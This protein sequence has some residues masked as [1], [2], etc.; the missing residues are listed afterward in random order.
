MSHARAFIESGNIEVATANSDGTLNLI[1]RGEAP[2]LVRYE[3]AY[4]ATTLTVMG[5]RSGFAWNNPPE[6]NYVDTLVYDKLERI[7]VV[8]SDLCSDDEFLRRVYID[9]T[10][11]PPSRDTVIAF[12]KDERDSKVKRDELVDKL[13][14]SPEFVEYWTNKWADL[15]QV[16]RKFLGEQAAVALRDWIKNAVATNQPYDDFARDILTA[17]GSNLQNPPASYYKAIRDPSMLMENTTAPVPGRA[18]QLQ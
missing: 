3:G 17:S 18:I 5:D 14:G 9:L 2:V 12:L 11:L 8:P 16:N 7:K 15:L 4:A 10:G 6:F 13:V 1:R